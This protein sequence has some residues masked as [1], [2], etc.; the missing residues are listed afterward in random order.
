MATEI[1][2]DNKEVNKLLKDI[3]TNVK[4]IK[5]RTKAFTGILSAIVFEDI[6]RHFEQAPSG[7]ASKTFRGS[8][9]VSW[10]AWSNRYQQRMTRLGKGG[11]K[12]LQD[13]GRLRGGW[14]PVRQNKQ[15]RTGKFG[16]QWYN[17]VKYAG[18]HDEGGGGIPQRKFTWLSK[19]AIGKMED[20]MVRFL[21]GEKVK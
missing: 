6:I 15:V 1:T 13:T 2:F 20:Q 19:D 17:P 11:N 18:R 21:E 7:F 4:A 12:Q 3:G 8:G 10:P 9:G 16:V 14:M 5:G